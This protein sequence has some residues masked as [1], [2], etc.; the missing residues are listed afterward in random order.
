[1]LEYKLKRLLVVAY[2]HPDLGRTMSGAYHESSRSH[3]FVFRTSSFVLRYFMHYRKV[4]LQDSL[5][6]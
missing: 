1:M 4:P 2:Y 6:D 3:L 5:A